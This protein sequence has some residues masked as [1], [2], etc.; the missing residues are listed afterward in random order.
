MAAHLKIAFG[1]D[2]GAFPWTTDP[3]REFSVLVEDGMTPAAAIQS[4]T[5]QA[6]KLMH[7]DD[8]VGVIEPGKLADIVAVPGNP[9]DQIS[10]MEKVDF[11]MKNGV[12]Y[13]SPET[14]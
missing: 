4:A 6:A 8:K 3:A 2:A 14:K 1:T 12:I 13:R 11:V 5:M 9:L 10:L 7:L